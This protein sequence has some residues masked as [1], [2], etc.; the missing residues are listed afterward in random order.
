MEKVNLEGGAATGVDLVER[1]G[2][3][4]KNVK[5]R[6][7]VILCAGPFGSPQL[8][9]LSGIGPKEHLAEHG[10]EVVKDLPEVGKNLVRYILVLSLSSNVDIS[11]FPKARSLRRLTLLPYTDGRVSPRA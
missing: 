10:I 11:V 6:K 9:M 3:T 8:L 1:Y 4:R 7:E 5:A 2:T